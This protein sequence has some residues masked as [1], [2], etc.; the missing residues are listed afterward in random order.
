MACWGYALGIAVY[1]PGWPVVWDYP[2]DAV[3]GT[4]REHAKAPDGY[5]NKRVL[6]QPGSG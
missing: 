6:S 5:G 2:L 1:L 3:H 4:V